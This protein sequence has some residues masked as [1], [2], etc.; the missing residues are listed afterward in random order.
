MTKL[1]SRGNGSIK[2]AVGSGSKG[3]FAN[4]DKPRASALISNPGFTHA[5]QPKG[6]NGGKVLKRAEHHQGTSMGGKADCIRGHR[7]PLVPG[8]SVIK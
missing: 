7:N 3:S 1:S 8:G 5:S 2:P 4:I 6:G